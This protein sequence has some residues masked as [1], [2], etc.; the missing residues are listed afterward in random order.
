MLRTIYVTA[1]TTEPK[2]K[3]TPCIVIDLENE[4]SANVPNISVEKII[5]VLWKL[6]HFSINLTNIAPTTN[7]IVLDKK[8]KEY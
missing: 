7:P 6:K 1:H 4:N 2:N 5:K 8:K 3:Y